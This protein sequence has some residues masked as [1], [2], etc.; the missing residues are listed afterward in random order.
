MKIT[1]VLHRQT[2][3]QPGYGTFRAY[4]VQEGRR[5]ASLLGGRQISN[6]DS[7]RRAASD[8]LLRN[9]PGVEIEWL[10]D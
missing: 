5:G 8:R 2:K 10:E 3:E 4:V 1:V 6:A 7:A 9:N